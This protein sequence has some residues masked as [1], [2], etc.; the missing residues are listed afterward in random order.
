MVSMHAYQ[1]VLW[2]VRICCY[3]SLILAIILSLLVALIWGE[4]V[5][6]LPP[7]GGLSCPSPI[8]LSIADMV[9]TVLMWSILTAIPPLLAFGGLVLLYFDIGRLAMRRTQRGGT[10]K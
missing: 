9:A 7:D 1:S 6:E 10:K 5:C 3:G 8:W 2:L 4:I